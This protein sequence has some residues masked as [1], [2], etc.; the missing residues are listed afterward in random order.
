MI[1]FICLLMF[2]RISGG[3]FNP[4]ITLIVYIEG[5]LTAKK[6]LSYILPQLGASFLAAMVAL[7]ILN[8]KVGP[9]IEKY[10]IIG[11]SDRNPADHVFA[12][13]L[14][15]L[16]GSAL[17]FLFVC[18]QMNKKTEVSTSP[19]VSSL[20]ISAI[21]FISRQYMLCVLVFRCTVTMENS[22]FN[23]AAALGLEVFYGAYYGA[24][25]Q[26]VNITTYI[27][28]PWLGGIVA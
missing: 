22:L 4:V 11:V 14:A 19:I 9:Y 16:M 10:P 3:H 15:E 25:D 12:T 24:W 23:P 28:G 26:W 13:I 18:V 2:G 1:Y 20:F 27:A 17:F 6:A 5:Q 7:P 21:F 8:L